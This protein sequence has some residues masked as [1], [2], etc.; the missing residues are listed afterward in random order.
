VRIRDRLGISPRRQRQL[1]RGMQLALVGFV[2]VGVDRGDVGIVVNA[3]VALGVT[4]LPG[5]LERDLGLPMDA[6]LTLWVTLAVFL[7]ALGTVGLLGT[8]VSFYQSVPWWDSL[9]HALS[10][11]VVAAAGYAA[12]RA[13]DVHLE[14][15]HLPARFTFVFVLVF[16]LAFGV[17]WEVLEF[18]IGGAASLL[19]TDQVLTQYGVADTMTDLLFD[20]A[21]GVLVA[22]YGE[23]HLTDVTGAIADRLAARRD[24][25]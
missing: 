25:A 10:A 1:V 4:Y 22:L 13:V 21:G 24:G 14:S 11:S 17:L 9:T 12:V 7:H 8:E 16:V 18:G 5:L 23:A 6:G 3:A 15:V 20:A 2:F 19:G